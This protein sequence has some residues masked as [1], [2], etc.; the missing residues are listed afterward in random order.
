V[1]PASNVALGVYPALHDIPLRRLVEAGARVA[2]GAD[3]PLLF[4]SRLLPQYATARDA[5][6]FDDA[7][8]AHLAR[9]SIEASTAPADVAKRLLTGVEEWLGGPQSSQPTSTGSGTR[10]TP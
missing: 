5:H 2:L 4:G 7:G 8:L 10:S 9:S 3:D 6:G 1:C